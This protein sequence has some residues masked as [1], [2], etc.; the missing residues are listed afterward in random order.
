MKVV[1]ASHTMG[2]VA[3]VGKIPIFC[4]CA[5]HHTSQNN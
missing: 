1:I 4:Q 3:E 2:W 5:A